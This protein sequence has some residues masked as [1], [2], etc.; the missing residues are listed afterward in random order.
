MEV[1]KQVSDIA[2]SLEKIRSTL[3]GHTASFAD[4]KTWKQNVDAKV[5]DV[6]SK[7]ADLSTSVTDLRHQIE[8]I[9]LHHQDHGSA[10]KVFDT[11]EIDLTKPVG[12]HL[13]TSPSGAASGPNG[14]CDATNNRGSGYG[15]VTTLQPPPV[16]GANPTFDLSLVFL[17][18]PSTLFLLLVRKLL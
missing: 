6:D 9:T 10:Y 1:D 4:L 15:V 12:A 8:R 17:L 3:E 18:C 5:S 7:V 11:E 13:V 2:V 14:H 16:T